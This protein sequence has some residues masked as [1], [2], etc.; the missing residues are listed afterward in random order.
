MSIVELQKVSKTYRQGDTDVHALQDVTLEVEKGEFVAILG[1][2]GSGKSTLLKIIGGLLKPTSGT[3]RVQ[4][5]EVDKLTAS[6]AARLRRKYT[7]VIFQF[8]NL[9]EE[10]TVAENMLLT[11]SLDKRAVEKEKFDEMADFLGLRPLLSKFPSQLSG[12]EQQRTAIARALLSQSPVLLADEPTGNLDSHKS[13]EIAE[14]FVRCK[15]QFGQTILMVTHNERVA[16]CADRRIVLCDGR[17][18][19]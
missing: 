19:G 17:L 6:G 2:S 14:L 11:A 10:L 13:M 3:V 18:A 9:V 12:G 15:K 1:P 7:G 4:D 5:M 16:A 8:F